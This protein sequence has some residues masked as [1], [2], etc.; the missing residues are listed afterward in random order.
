MNAEALKVI[1]IICLVV[2]GFVLVGGLCFVIYLIGRASVV[3]NPNKVAV[4]IKSG[5]T[6]LKPLKGKMVKR[7]KNGTAYKYRG[8][9]FTIR[10]SSY[11]EIYY[12]GRITVFLNKIGQVIASPFTESET[13]ADGEK[14][15]L[16]YKILESHIGEGA[17]NAVSSKKKVPNFILMAF[18]AIAIIVV[19]FIGYKYYE[20]NMTQQPPPAPVATI[21]DNTSDYKFE[22]R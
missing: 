3:N 4:F 2:W 15:T 14:E 5:N 1:V 20:T 16:I 12:N 11:S 19:G 18:I 17:V 10:P 6:L 13:L 9:K 22:V 21:T 8:G 7:V